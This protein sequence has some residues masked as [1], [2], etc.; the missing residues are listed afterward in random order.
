MW[1][2]LP[3]LDYSPSDFGDY[4]SAES[5]SYHYGKHHQAY[6]DQTNKLIQGTP[7]ESESLERIVMEAEGKLFNQ[8]AQAWN[9]AFFWKSLSPSSQR[10]SKALK[11]AIESAFGSESSFFD[12]WKEKGSAQFGS[13]W[14]WLVE[15]SEA[16]DGKRS[17]SILTTSNAENPMTEGKKPLLCCDLWEHAY[18]IDHRNDRGAFLEGFPKRAAWDFASGNFEL[19]GLPDMTQFMVID[20][21]WQPLRTETVTKR[22]QAHDSSLTNT[23]RGFGSSR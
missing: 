21:S 20:S 15:D 5:F 1:F 6:V 23:S 2:Q 7:F 10:P 9:H 4:L 3:K 19:E 18:Y 12:Q 11:D 17:L 14:I 8:A 16:K 22:S 13:G